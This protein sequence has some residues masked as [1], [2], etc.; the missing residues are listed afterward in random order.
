[1][2]GDFVLDDKNKYFSGRTNRYIGKNKISA[3]GVTKVKASFGVPFTSTRAINIIKTLN[4]THSQGM[5]SLIGYPWHG[6]I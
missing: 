5:H 6:L 1:M 3:R 2:V 4:Y